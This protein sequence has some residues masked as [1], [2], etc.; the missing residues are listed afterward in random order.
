MLDY[1]HFGV[2]ADGGRLRISDRSERREE[3]KLILEYLKILFSVVGLVTVYFALLQWNAATKSANIAVYQ[4]MTGEWREHLKILI[5]KPG[6]RPYFESSKELLP[7]DENRELVLAFADIRLDVADG[8][9]SYARF[10]KLE[11]IDGWENT[12]AN[13]FRTSPVLCR[14]LDEAR[15][16]F[17]NAL[18]IPIAQAVCRSSLE[19][20]SSTK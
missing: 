7:D 1:L 12:V 13:A 8:L 9:L 11:G 6:I 15:S 20:K 14:R 5:E 18:I 4:R 3:I 10:Q 16:S 19:R 17:A 2:C